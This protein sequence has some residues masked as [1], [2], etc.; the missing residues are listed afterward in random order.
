M[1]SLLTPV[2][3][4]L[5]SVLTVYTFM[6]FVPETNVKTMQFDQNSAV[7]LKF[8]GDDLSKENV[9][10]YVNTVCAPLLTVDGDD[11]MFYFWYG[12]VNVVWFGL[13]VLCIIVWIIYETGVPGD[14]FSPLLSKIFSLVVDFVEY[15]FLITWSMSKYLQYSDE[16]RHRA[17]KAQESLAENVEPKRCMEIN[18]GATE[19]KKAVS[20]TGDDENYSIFYLH[21][22]FVH[23]FFV[24]V[25]FLIVLRRFLAYFV[26]FTK[27]ASET[28]DIIIKGGVGVNS[29]PQV[30]VAV[31][32]A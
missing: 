20:T 27:K 11:K 14:V 3:Y 12:V 16:K 31:Q 7:D 10:K 8:F 26:D 18:W 19:V 32:A 13:S 21:L 15:L 29:L 2:H 1:Y 9:A 24:A 22:L 25:L 6:A 5:L 28:K 4:I 23:W 30:Y 17:F